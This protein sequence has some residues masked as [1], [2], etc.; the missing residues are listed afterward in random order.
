[1]T[2]RNNLINWKKIS[3]YIAISFGFCWTIALIMKLAHI[4]YGSINSFIIIGGF[5]MPGPALATFIVQKYIFKEGFKQ[6]GWRFDK[7][8]YK[9]FLKTILIFLAIILLTFA[10]IGLFGN[11]HIISQFGQID[12]SQE[13]FNFQ[14]K[15]LLKGKLDIDKIKL[16]SIPSALFFILMIIEG[17]VAG[18]TVNLPFMFGEEFGWRG[19]MLKETQKLGFLKSNI[20]IGTIWGLWHLPVI[21]MG[22]N[23]PNHPYFGIVMM[24]LMTIALAPIFAYVRLKTKSILGAC[25]LHGMINATAALFTLYIANA[26]ELYSS[27]AGWAGV[28][29]CTVLTILIY[30]FDKTFV[31]NYSELEKDL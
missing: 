10:V 26:N 24:C 13:N 12:F 23:Y 16:P 30:F 18:L 19:L 9:W 1:M 27:I 17:I 14:F 8:N 2:E 7:K 11:T 28:I 22:H 20:F 21:L 31:E 15:E 3:I 6:Y 4:D 5:Y 29:A 25:I